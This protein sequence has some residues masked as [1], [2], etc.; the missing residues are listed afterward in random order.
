MIYTIAFFYIL[1]TLKL[2]KF[3]LS[4]TKLVVFTW[5]PLLFQCSY[6]NE[7]Y[8]NPTKYT[9]YTSGNFPIAFLSSPSAMESINKSY[10]NVS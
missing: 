5:N 10:Q 9:N 2:L 8:H 1:D 6:L 3:K 7:W 4:N